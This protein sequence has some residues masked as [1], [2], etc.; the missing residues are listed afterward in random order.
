[1]PT[2]RKARVTRLPQL[3]YPLLL[4]MAL[5][6]GCQTIAVPTVTPTRTLSG[7]TLAPTDNVIPLPPTELPAGFEDRTGSSGATAAALP[8]SLDLPPLAI[9]SEGSDSVQIVQITTEGDDVLIGALYAD[10]PIRAPGVVLVAEQ[11]EVWGNFPRTLEANGYITLV[12]AVPPDLT[13]AEFVQVLGSFT[14]LAQGDA[15]RLD[16]GRIAVIGEDNGALVALR[17]CVIDRRC[18]VLGLLS[19]PPTDGL[20]LE[21]GRYGDRPLLVS[22]SRTDAGRF[23]AAQQAAAAGLGVVQFQPF[24]DAGQGAAMISARPDFEDLLLTWLA[25]HLRG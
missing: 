20:A 24:D 18:D 17:G 12:I 25:R 15:A 2:H 3:R 9:T 6:A 7:A 4:L 13:T 11:R 5:L 8:N 16:P 19:I 1:M 10:V 23:R 22:A 21:A 14:D